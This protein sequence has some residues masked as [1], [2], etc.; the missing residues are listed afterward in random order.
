MFSRVDLSVACSGAG[1]DEYDSLRHIMRT[2]RP[3]HMA[4]SPSAT[5][6]S[7]FMGFL[8]FATVVIPLS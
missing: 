6:T 5:W 7:P 2:L 8:L 3:I 1:I 4:K